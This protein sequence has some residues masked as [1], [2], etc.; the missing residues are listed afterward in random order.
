M[1]ETA[2]LTQVSIDLTNALLDSADVKTIGV[3]NW[4]GRAQTALETA[5]A[6]AE[7]AGH[8]VTI[9]ARKL[10]ID[11]LS[12]ASAETI[13]RVSPII[14]EHWQEWAQNVARESVYIVALARVAREER[15][16]KRQQET[17]TLNDILEGK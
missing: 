2:D 12:K 16:K 13:A 14:D 1:T 4:W 8:A 9:A 17:L 6:G 3:S 11:T 5:A 7:N 15:K 10:Q